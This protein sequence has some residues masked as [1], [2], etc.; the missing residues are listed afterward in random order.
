MPTCTRGRILLA[1]LAFAGIG[2][3]T[4]SAD[5]PPAT[6]FIATSGSDANACT[7]AAPCLTMNRAYRLATPG[8]VV[9]SRG[10]LI[11]SAT[12]DV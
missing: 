6:I 12:F 2:A 10:R 9:E 4:A 5:S 1:V 3:A 7:A 11:P 8:A